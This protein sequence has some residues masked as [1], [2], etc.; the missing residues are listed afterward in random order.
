MIAQAGCLH[1]EYGFKDDLTNYEPSPIPRT[2]RCL[3][4]VAA[5]KF[6]THEYL[7]NVVG[8]SV[9]LERYTEKYRGPLQLPA[10]GVQ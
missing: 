10:G 2:L 8:G 5:D 6:D 4:E 1:D 7:A 9:K 3:I